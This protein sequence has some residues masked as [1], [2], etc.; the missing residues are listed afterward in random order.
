MNAEQFLLVKIAEEAAEVAQIALKTAQFGSFERMNETTPTN[1]ERLNGELNDLI[2][3]AFYIFNHYQEV[4]TKDGLT[5][6]QIDATL[7]KNKVEKIRKYYNYSAK[8]GLVEKDDKF[9]KDLNN[10]VNNGFNF[11]NPV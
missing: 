11:L 7:V 6:L 3:V 2:A 9:I 1:V 10:L 5:P 4:R 8:L